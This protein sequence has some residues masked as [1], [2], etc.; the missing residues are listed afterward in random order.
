LC[1]I[2]YWDPHGKEVP[3]RGFQDKA[4]LPARGE[5]DLW[6]RQGEILTAQAFARLAENQSKAFDKLEE[7]SRVHNAQ[8]Q[9]IVA[10][11][12]AEFRLSAARSNLQSLISSQMV[13]IVA[14]QKSTHARQGSDADLGGDIGRARLEVRTLERQLFDLQQSSAAVTPLAPPHP[15]NPLARLFVRR[16]ISFG[17]LFSGGGQP[18]HGS[19][20]SA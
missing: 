1:T 4:S 12:L 2:D 9:S 10:L 13:V 3:T 16:Q 6:A 5:D 7:M 19:G 11:C 8:L 20:N 15:S 14:A 17:A 18:A